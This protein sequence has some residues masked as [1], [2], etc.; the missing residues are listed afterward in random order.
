MKA[1]SLFILCVMSALASLGQN[2]QLG[3]APVVIIQDE[4]IPENVL[5]LLNSRLTTALSAS[6]ITSDESIGQ[7]IIAGRFNHIMEDVVAG[8]PMQFAVHTNLTIFIGSSESKQIFSSKSF[9]LRGVGT[10]KQKALINCLQ[11]INA[12]NETFEQLVEDGRKKI[13]AYFDNNYKQ[14]LAKASQAASINEFDKA[15][16]YAT[17]I[18]ECSQG[19]HSSCETAE[20]IFKKYIDYDSQM[21]LAQ[22]KVVWAAS[23][24]NIG[25]KNAS[26]FL[27]LID[28]NSKSGAG[29]Q[30]L[31]SEIKKITRSDYEFEHVEIHNDDM[32]IKT[33]YIDAAK[34]IGVAYGR[35]QQPST[36]NISWM[37]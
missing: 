7:F 15:L 12:K 17:S 13:I 25:A 31:I 10:S 19:Y 3:I 11:S 36:T 21:L 35:G 23:P 37:K 5:N 24:N 2:C 27:R 32:A 8:P 9:D 20:T 6:G 28:P 26:C 14:I 16:Y 1:I 34:Q 30:I 29:A 22:A 18:P 4:D 33:A